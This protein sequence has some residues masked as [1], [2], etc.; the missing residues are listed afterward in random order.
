MRKIL[1]VLL[2][3]SSLF[4]ASLYTLDNV[5]SLTL[6]FSNQTDFL[7]QDQEAMLKKMLT[8]KLKNGGFLLEETD[9][10]VFVVKIDA[11]EIE[12]TQ[13]IHTEVGLGEDVITKRKGKI[14]T[15]AYT[16]LDSQ[17]IEGYSD[18]YKNTLDSLTLLVDAFINA[19]KEDNE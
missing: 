17:F 2:L 9:A 3:S 4:S 10:P 8:E 18:P 14:G 15:F 7:N 16:Y 6:Y 13:A 19:H 11:L 5:H 1:L 12:G